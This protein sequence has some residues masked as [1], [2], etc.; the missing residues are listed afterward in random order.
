V[1]VLGVHEILHTNWKMAKPGRV[2]VRFGAPLHL[3]GD[4]YASLAKQV[5]D[6]VRAL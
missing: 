4:D 5:E 2:E 3:E 6:A 1:R